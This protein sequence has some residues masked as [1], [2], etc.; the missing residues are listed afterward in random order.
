M[1]LRQSAT[2]AT[3]GLLVVVSLAASSA[4]SRPGP[5]QDHRTRRSGSLALP[6]ASNHALIAGGALTVGVLTAFGIA[7]LANEVKPV[8]SAL[9]RLQQLNDQISDEDIRKVQ[10]NFTPITISICRPF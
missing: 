6:S 5:S 8:I 2:T 7:T 3:L 4:V 10:G 1:K 9:Q